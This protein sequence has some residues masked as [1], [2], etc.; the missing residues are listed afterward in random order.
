MQTALG[1]TP[2][3][4]GIPSLRVEDPQ[5]VHESLQK[6]FANRDPRSSR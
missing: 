3:A 6:A 2:T 5:K 4:V 1:R